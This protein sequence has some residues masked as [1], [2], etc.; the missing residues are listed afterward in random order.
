MATVVM[1]GCLSSYSQFEQLFSSIHS[2]VSSAC[3]STDAAFR[4]VQIMKSDNQNNIK[5]YDQKD[6]A[7]GEIKKVGVLTYIEDVRSGDLFLYE[8]LSVIRVK[9]AI[10]ALG[11]PFYTFGKMAWHIAKTPIEIGAIVLETLFNLGQLLYAAQ[12]D[13]CGAEGIK[14][15]SQ[16]FEVLQ[17]GCYEIVKAPIFGLGCEI[18][19]L[20]GTLKPYHGRKYEAMIERAWQAGISYREDFRNVSLDGEENYWQAFRKNMRDAHP[21]YLAHC[22]QVRNNIHDSHITVIRRDPL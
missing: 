19:A 22:F 21:F 11:M 7:T 18:A 3:E 4:R 15:I 10:I 17:K 20:Y 5:L 14:G 12:F 13:Q 8:S 1:R 2:L 6:L 9:C 16:S